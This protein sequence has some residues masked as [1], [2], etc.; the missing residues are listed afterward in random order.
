MAEISIALPL[1]SGGFLRRECP[2]CLRELKWR[3]AADEQVPYAVPAAGLHCPYCA[4]QAPLDAWW[5]PAQ[6]EVV[7][8]RAFDEVLG[9]ELERLGR[10]AA[11]VTGPVPYAPPALVEPDDMRRVDFACHP[12][13]PVKVLDHWSGDVHCLVCGQTA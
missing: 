5:T 9:P 8:A 3:S 6:L 2:A 10:S 1:D 4:E 13:E 12:L 7:N 11:D